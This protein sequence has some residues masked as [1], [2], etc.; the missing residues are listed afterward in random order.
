MTEEY[1][2]H[3]GKLIRV[4]APPEISDEAEQ[5]WEKYKWRPMI[6]ENIAKEWFCFGFDA[7][8]REPKRAKSFTF[9]SRKPAK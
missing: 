2:D 8:A 4:S 6:F 7:A 9:F 1:I 5:A 3:D